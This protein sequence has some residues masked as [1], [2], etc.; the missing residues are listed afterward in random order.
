MIQTYKARLNKLLDKIDEYC[1]INNLN[2]ID[3]REINSH[4]GK[5]TVIMEMSYLPD[6]DMTFYLDDNGILTCG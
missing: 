6:S 5:L 2:P 1:E 3:V 4:N